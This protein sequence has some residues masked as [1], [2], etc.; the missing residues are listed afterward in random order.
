MKQLTTNIEINASASK[1]WNILTNFDEYPQWNPFIRAVSGEVKQGARLEV[2]LQP[3]GGGMMTFR[4]T[5][6]VA[7]PEREFRW[8]GQLLLPGIFNGEHYFQIE[9]L[10]SD[11]IRFIHSEVFSGLLVPFLAKSLDTNTKSGFEKMNQALKARAE[12]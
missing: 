5:V 11:C 8:L 10:G 1:V 2:Q 7:E 12:I 6:L 4:P 9:P 3:P